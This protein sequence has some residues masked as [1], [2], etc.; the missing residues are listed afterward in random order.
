MLNCGQNTAFDELDKV[1]NDTPKSIKLLNEIIVLDKS[2]AI[3]KLKQEKLTAE[4][5]AIVVKYTHCDNPPEDFYITSED[6]VGKAGVWGHFGSWDFNRAVMYLNT[7]QLS[8]AE[9]V[10]YLVENFNLS[11]EEAEQLHSEIKSTDA[12]RWVSPWPGYITGPQGCEKNAE[13]KLRCVGSIQ[14]KNYI[15]NID[16]TDYSAKFESQNEVYPNSMVYATQKEIVE[17][18][19][20]GTTAGFS[21]ILIPTGSDYVLLAADPLQANSVF[22]QLFFMQGHGLKCF[23]KFDETQNI[24]GGRII[25]WRMDYNCQQHNNAFF[26]E[27]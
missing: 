14:G 1:L 8:R 21:I 17:K 25:T 5:A 7:K 13:N 20:T 24:N 15:I 26:A 22:T 12:D 18:Q 6:M 23:S 19:F 2:A 10:P 4:E 11:S 27:E 16:L 3:R 9:A